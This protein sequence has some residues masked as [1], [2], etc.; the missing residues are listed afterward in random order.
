MTTH[1]KA[2]VEI[3]KGQTKIYLAQPPTRKANDPTRYF[4]V[5]PSVGGG[6]FTDVSPV[7]ER[8][9]PKG[10]RRYIV[11]G[12]DDLQLMQ[13]IN[14]RGWTD[15]KGNNWKVFYLTPRDRIARAYL[16]PRASKVNNMDDLGIHTRAMDF[17]DQGPKVNKYQGRIIVPNVDKFVFG[18]LMSSDEETRVGSHRLENGRSITVRHLSFEGINP[19]IKAMMDGVIFLNPHG[20][21]ALGLCSDPD[22]KDPSTRVADAARGL[23]PPKLG[24]AWYG[25]YTDHV[26]LGKGTIVLIPWLKYDVVV[27]GTKEL[28]YTDFTYAASFGALGVSVPHSDAQSVVNFKQHKMLRDTGISFMKELYSSCSNAGKLRKFAIRHIRALQKTRA[29]SGEGIDYDAYVLSGLFKRHIDPLMFPF[30]MRRLIRLMTHAISDFDRL[31]VP[32]DKTHKIAHVIPDVYCIDEQGN[33]DMSKSKVPAGYVAF[34]DLPHNTE[35]VLTRQPNENTNAHIIAKVWNPEDDNPYRKFRGRGLV[36]LGPGLDAENPGALEFLE[37]LGGGDMDDTFIITHDPVLVNHFRT[38]PRYPEVDKAAILA[39]FIQAQEFEEMSE[40]DDW[41]VEFVDSLEEF[42][43]YTDRYRADD[44]TVVFGQKQFA[45]VLR[46]AQRAGIGIGPVVNALIADFML[47]DPEYKASILEC[48]DSAIASNQAKLDKLDRGNPLYVQAIRQLTA[49]IRL[50]TSKR[51]WL[52]ERVPYQGARLATFLELV[53]DGAAKGENMEVLGMDVGAWVRNFHIDT[54]IYP[55][56]CSWGRKRPGIDTVGRIPMSKQKAKDYILVDTPICKVVK[57][58]TVLRNRMLENLK[59]LQWRNIK[60][61]L[62]EVTDHFYCDEEDTPYIVV[63][64]NPADRENDPGIL[65]IWNQGWAD[66]R[67]DYGDSDAERNKA[68]IDLEQ[69]VYEYEARYELT[70]EEMMTLSVELYKHLYRS[71][72]DEAELDDDGKVREFPD[73]LLGITQHA[74]AFFAALDQVKLNKVPITAD[75]RMVELDHM[76][77]YLI[78]STVN[79]KVKEGIVYRVVDNSALGTVDDC[80]D[81]TYVMDCGEITLREVNPILT[82]SGN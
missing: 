51:K 24:D 26:G 31:R 56:M 72:Y 52:E 79:V 46:R 50:F 80:L 8:Q 25:H 41:A 63:H 16:V 77:S 35:V 47:S 7:I 45:A 38:L 20:A 30:A 11:L 28:V 39:E 42:D 55:T 22:E 60:L 40:V 19:R 66:F 74:N 1:M 82:C 44:D 9:M 70:D 48:L 18:K 15:N 5:E 65:K 43:R 73:G 61:A 14:S 33:C 62:Y 34:A 53:I 32:L 67:N 58:L 71:E 3:L 75:T 81:G 13:Q 69:K 2:L 17:Y 37:R 59:H 12:T 78:D 36:L 4:R 49:I 6:Y 21:I 57:E 23:R 27:P 76:Y 68:H 54:Q 64:G 29:M 10:S